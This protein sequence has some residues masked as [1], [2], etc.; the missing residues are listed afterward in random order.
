MVTLNNN[1]PVWVRDSEHGF[2]LGKITDIGSD[3][4]T[5]QLNENKKVRRQLRVVLIEMSL[6][7]RL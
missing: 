1:K 5:V 7:S 4:V 2:I 6:S 3:Q